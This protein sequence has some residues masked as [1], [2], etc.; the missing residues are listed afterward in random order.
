MRRKNTE[1]LK[2]VI[3]RYLRITGVEKRLKE[4][5]LKNQWEDIIGKGI[6]SRT[7]KIEIKDGTVYLLINSSI[8]K[9]ELR[10]VK[11]DIIRRF[12]EAAGEPLIRELK[13]Y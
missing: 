13:I 1:P 12:N 6:A 5:R 7:E 11:S 8:V 2:H 10:M 4:I 9:N 3:K